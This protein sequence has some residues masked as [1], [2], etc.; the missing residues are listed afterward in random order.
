M[1]VPEPGSSSR[2]V[3]TG[4]DVVGSATRAVERHGMKEISRRRALQLGA[5]GFLAAAVGPA[6]A[7]A[8]TGRADVPPGAPLVEP[9]TLRSVD[10]ALEVWLEAAE[11]PV[12]IG[13]RAATAL[14]YNGS[15]PGPTLRVR[16][17]DRLQVELVNRLADPTNLHVH[18]LHVSPAFNGDNVLLPVQP[19]A[20]FSYEHQVPSDHPPGVYWYHPHQ[21]MVVADQVF[22]GLYGTIVVEDP[23]E[24]PVTRERVLVI[25]DITLDSAGRPSAPATAD[26]VLGREGE[27]V[28]VNGQ[29]RPT[30]T[31]RPGERERW[32]IVNACVARFLRLRLD[33]QQLELLGIDSGRYAE[34]Q[35]VDEVVLLSGNRADLLVTATEGTSALQVLGLARGTMPGMDRLSGD[36][37]TVA[38]LQVAG[39]RTPALPPVP[40][41]PPPRDLRGVEPVTRRRLTFGM[42]SGGDRMS[43]GGTV[44]TIDGRQFDPARTDLTVAVGTVEEWTIANAS[45]M[46]HPMHLHVWPMQLIA[47]AGGPMESIIWRDVI[48]VPAAG[49]ITVRVA[50]DDFA[51]RTVYHCHI[52]DHE[53]LGMM[54]VIEAHAAG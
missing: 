14:T 11:S 47:G 2:P 31:A 19:G 6:W 35:R 10:G 5:V 22:G 9:E 3:G 24:V 13:G 50:F 46:D 51:G 16:P 33:G 39:S 26:Q 25:S 23:V 18:G 43:A 21:H 15:L 38:T 17:G 49:E 32:R 8:Q 48:N 37:G 36:V 7:W 34:P 1:S 42:G 52:L 4:D 44:F 41:A 54:G 27:L 30:L 12:T 20:A 45:T 40:A 28:L 53:D 29:V